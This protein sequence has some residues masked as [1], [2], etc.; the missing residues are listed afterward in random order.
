MSHRSHSQIVRDV[1][2][3]SIRERLATLGIAVADPTVRS[4]ERRKSGAGSIPAE[5]WQP[6]ADL[7]LT[8]LEELAAAKA[9]RGRAM[10]AAA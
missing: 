1:G 5:Y 3:T 8:T 10:G 4:W 9:A 6:L 2:V 7:E